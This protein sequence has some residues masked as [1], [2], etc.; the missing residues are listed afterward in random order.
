MSTPS[1]EKLTADSQ[2]FALDAWRQQQKGE[3]SGKSG[4]PLI[5]LAAH[6]ESSVAA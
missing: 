3:N 2:K 5:T 4:F 6:W 1:K